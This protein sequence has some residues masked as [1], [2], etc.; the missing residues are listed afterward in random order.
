M[1]RQIVNSLSMFV[2][3]TAAFAVAVVSAKGQS[4]RA[5]AQV[6]FDFVIGDKVLPAGEYT[7]N[8]MTQDG[9]ILRIHN[10]EAGQAATRV[11]ITVVAKSRNSQSRL[12]FHR[13][14]QTYFLAEVWREGDS[15]GRLLTQSKKER[16]MRHE[17]GAVAQ[18]KCD[19]VELVATLR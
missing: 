14:G 16:S 10:D 18:N 13:Y 4:I 8:S 12:I 3:L 19:T 5:V 7:V 15:E 11:T 17:L 6:P 1:K 2:M 9:S